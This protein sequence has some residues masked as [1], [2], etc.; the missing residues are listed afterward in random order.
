MTMKI[1]SNLWKI[2]HILSTLAVFD[3]AYASTCHQDQHWQDHPV[4]CRMLEWAEHD[5]EGFARHAHA[6][7]EEQSHLVQVRNSRSASLDIST[8][9]RRI[10]GGKVGSENKQLPVVFAHGMGD[11]CF[12]SGMQHVAQLAS[13]WLS[14]DFGPDRSNVYSVCIPTGATQAEDT[15]NGYFLSMDASVEVFAEGVRA[16]PRLSDGFHAIGFSQGNNVIRGYIA[17]HNT[18]TVETFISI[19]GVNAGIGAVPY[20]RPSETAMGAVRLGG[21][22]DLLMEQA[23]RSAYTEFAQEHSFQANY[24]RDPRPTAFPLYQKYGQL[25][26]WNN[27][28][29]LVNETL[30]TN[31]GKTSAFV[32][33]LA[34]EDGLVWPKEGEQWGQPDSKDPFHVILSINET[35]WYKEDL[36]GLRTANELGKNYFESFEGDHLQFESADLE[37]WVKTYLK[38]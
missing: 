18:P 15:K 6:W 11:S 31:W 29:G 34:T 38:N 22:C 9:K 8:T 27:E 32:W 20:C 5:L 16:D 1:R 25:A 12:N 28:A 2:L 36:F 33:V 14:E 24:W 7:A 23:S 26:A 4:L 13:E 17:K 19:N 3:K 35:T 30:K 21:M 10:Q 37:R